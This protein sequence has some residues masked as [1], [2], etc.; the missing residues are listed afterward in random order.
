MDLKLNDDQVMLKKVAAD[1]LKAEAPSYVITEWYQKK[2]AF[3]PE[4]Y[5]KTAEVGW[6]GM[7]LPEEFGGGGTSCTDCAVVFE[8][9]GRG[10]LPGPYFTCGVMAAQLILSGGSDGAKEK[11]A[12][13]DL[14]RQ[15]RCDSGD[16]RR[17]DSMGAAL[18]ADS[19]GQE[20]RR[21]HLERHQALRSRRRSGEPFHLRG[22]H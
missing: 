22:T 14:R 5:K 19:R 8:E 20:R 3:I 6:L 16:L 1:F 4:L 2:I 13:E 18:G 17:S 11:L 9:L 15:R 21:F 12:A 7:I 10:P